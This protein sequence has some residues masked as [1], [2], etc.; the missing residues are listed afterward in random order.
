[1][2]ACRQPSGGRRGWIDV[3]RVTKVHVRIHTMRDMRGGRGELGLQ[4]IENGLE[5]GGDAVA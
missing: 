1:M 2:D 4:T 3:A 5:Q